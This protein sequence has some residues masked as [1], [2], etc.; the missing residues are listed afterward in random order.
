MDMYQSL[1]EDRD[2]WF[3]VAVARG[4]SLSVLVHAIKFHQKF[5]GEFET[6][7]KYTDEVIKDSNKLQLHFNV[8]FGEKKNDCEIK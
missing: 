3:N 7:C 6:I 5:G 1:K 8:N 2:N 4:S